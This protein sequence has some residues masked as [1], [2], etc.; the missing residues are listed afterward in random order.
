MR[1]VAAAGELV[2]RGGQL[3]VGNAAFKGFV[4]RSGSGEFVGFH[5]KMSTDLSRPLVPSIGLHDKLDGFITFREA[6]HATANSPVDAET[7]QFGN[8]DPV[9]AMPEQGLDDG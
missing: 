7:P 6:L 5:W 2:I 4:R 3:S 9:S 1:R 8:R